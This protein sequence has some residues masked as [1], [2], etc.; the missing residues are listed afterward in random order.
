VRKFLKEFEAE[1]YRNVEVEYVRGKPSVLTISDDDGNEIEEVQLFDIATNEEIHEMM[2]NKGFERKSDVEIVE[3]KAKK[4]KEAEEEQTR[5]AM[6]REERREARSRKLQEKNGEKD[7]DKREIKEPDYYI[8]EN[9][10]NVPKH[11]EM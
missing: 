1:E 9:G 7:N 11:D 6:E 8:D 3:M 2:I 4:Q 5:L 10:E